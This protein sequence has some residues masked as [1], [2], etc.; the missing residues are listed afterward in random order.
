M[1]EPRSQARVL[2]LFLC[3]CA[4]LTVGAAQA[5]QTPQQVV[6][7]FHAAMSKG[8]TKTMLNLLAPDVVIFEA[9]GAEM[10]RDEYRTH[11]LGADVAFAR[12]AKR[13]VTDSQAKV[14]GNAAWVLTRS[15]T[16]G[17]FQGK[18]VDSRGT[19]TM[20]LRKT[21]QGWRIVHI[22]WSAAN[23]KKAG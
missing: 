1:R 16:T 14:A 12:A 11:H 18:A 5:Q 7:A 9:G 4:A 6:A 23:T 3:L 10:N 19:E 8:D 13:T 2:L 17:T 21:P 20:V 15:T 22:H